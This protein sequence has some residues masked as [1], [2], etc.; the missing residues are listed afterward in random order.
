MT[1]IGIISDT[2]GDFLSPIREFLEPC[3]I[4]W[5]AGDIG[6]LDTYDEIRKFRPVIAVT[7]NIDDARTRTE[8]P[9]VQVFHIEQCKVVMTHIGGYP[10]RYA[11]G[12]KDLLIKEKPE[13]FVCGHSHILKIM[14]DPRLHLMHFNP[15]AAGKKGFHLHITAIRMDIHGKEM[16]NLEIFEL[17]RKDQICR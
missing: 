12:I 2:H 14:P 1:K 4:L 15:G 16:S 13:I 8:I 5:H 17:P 10:G 9:P 6:G 11:P 7:G 3:Q